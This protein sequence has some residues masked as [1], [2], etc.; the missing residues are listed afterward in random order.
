MNEFKDEFIGNTLIP[1]LKKLDPTRPWDNGFMEQKNLKVVDE[2]DEPHIYNQFVWRHDF[3]SYTDNN[4]VRIGQMDFWTQTPQIIA[5]ASAAQI[6][7]E[8]GWIWLW[9]NGM[10]SYLGH[11]F[12][13][14]YLGTFKDAHA[15]RELQAYDLQWETELFRVHREVAG[16]LA[17]DYLSGDYGM[18]GDWFIGNIKDL[19]PG[20]TL[21]WFK[22]CFAPSAVFIDLGDQRYRKDLKPYNPGENLVFNLIGVNDD[23]VT[24]KGS[25]NLYL[26]DSDGHMVS[27]HSYTMKIPHY[28]TALLPVKYKLPEKGGGY[29]LVCAYTKEGNKE[30]IICRRYIKVGYFNS[31]HFYE[32]NPGDL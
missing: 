30:P 29:L 28:L 5:D 18:T 14:Y 9:R 2:M 25:V 6:V 21:K 23:S 10:P 32:L 24:V 27:S 26:L 1:E 31:Y 19:T 8:Y 12:Y 4:P 17:F 22:N 20:P 11:K 16:V 13:T 7:N 15:N 3:E